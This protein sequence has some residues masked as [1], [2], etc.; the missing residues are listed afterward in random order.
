MKSVRGY[1]HDTEEVQEAVQDL[2]A[3]GYSE[4]ELQEDTERPYSES[5]TAATGPTIGYTTLIGAGLALAVGLP[6]GLLGMA[7]PNVNTEWSNIIIMVLTWSIASAVFGAIIG[8]V[9]G[10]VIQRGMSRS[11]T[12]PQSAP[13]SRETVLRVL[14]PDIDDA[15]RARQILQRHNGDR[16]DTL[17]AGRTVV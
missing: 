17:G 3:A 9:Y 16:I 5:A 7:L 14:V 2:R 12:V 13:A 15:A 10:A 8:A 6:I 11:V 4:I 1:F